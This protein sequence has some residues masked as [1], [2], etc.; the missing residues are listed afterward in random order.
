MRR[1]AAPAVALAASACLVLAGCA[2]DP[3]PRGLGAWD[4][5]ADGRVSR[6]EF[7][8]GADRA[9]LFPSWDSDGDGRLSRGEYVAGPATIPRFDIATRG[10]L[11]PG[12]GDWVDESEV[13]DGAFDSYDEDGSLWLDK[14]EFG[15]FERELGSQGIYR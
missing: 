9:G 12:E 10:D 5:D 4:S 11:E 2:A 7:R 15:R 3:A 8:Q 6:R 14:D 13:M 1:R